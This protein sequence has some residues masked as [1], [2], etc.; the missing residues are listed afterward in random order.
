MTEPTTAQTA[1]DNPRVP[2][3]KRPVLA[4][5]MMI[6][7]GLVVAGYGALAFSGRELTAPE[8]DEIPASVR[9]SPGGYRSYHFWHTG[10]HGGK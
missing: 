1:I 2:R 4:T 8:R 3:P 7:S 10:Y 9:A 5:V 6:F